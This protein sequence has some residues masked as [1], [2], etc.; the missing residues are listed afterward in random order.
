VVTL[1]PHYGLEL[2]GQH[3]EGLCHAHLNLK[4]HK[5]WKQKTIMI[6]VH[7]IYFTSVS[8][9]T[10]QVDFFLLTLNLVFIYIFWRPGLWWHHRIPSITT[11]LWLFYLCVIN[12]EL[13]KFV[14]VPWHGAVD[15]NFIN[16][17]HPTNPG[18]L[19]EWS[20]RIYHA[21][22]KLITLST[23]LT[24]YLIEFGGYYF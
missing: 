24:F 5:E 22:N 9:F 19:W 14:A 16:P 20:I 21:T 15:W 13:I 12:P 23:I 4:F 10:V 17:N 3:T 7:I 11:F 18:K 1:L 6:R 2:W 8:F